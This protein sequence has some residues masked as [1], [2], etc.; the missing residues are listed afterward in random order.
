MLLRAMEYA[1]YKCK[2]LIALVEL[3]ND[4]LINYSS[5]KLNDLGVKGKIPTSQL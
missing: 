4:F 3:W 1:K 2:D 5:A